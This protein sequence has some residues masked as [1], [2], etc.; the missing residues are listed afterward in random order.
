MSAARQGKGCGINVGG[1]QA[2]RERGCSVFFVLLGRSEEIN[3][4]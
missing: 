2:G 4:F 3:R 1:R